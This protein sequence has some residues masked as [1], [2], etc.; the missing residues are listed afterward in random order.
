LRPRFVWIG[1]GGDVRAYDGLAGAPTGAPIGTWSSHVV[2]ERTAIV[3]RFG[4]FRWI[5]LLDWPPPDGEDGMCVLM[6]P[7]ASARVPMRP[8][9]GEGVDKQA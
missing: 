6:K 4:G 8:K 5:C 3:A 2:A 9:D 7:D 1:G